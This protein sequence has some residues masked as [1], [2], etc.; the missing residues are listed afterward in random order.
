M[1]SLPELYFETSQNIWR[2]P[3]ENIADQLRKLLKLHLVNKVFPNKHVIC[4]I[5]Q[6]MFITRLMDWLLIVIVFTPFLK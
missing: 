4:E 3:P 2:A 5:A 6:N 1:M